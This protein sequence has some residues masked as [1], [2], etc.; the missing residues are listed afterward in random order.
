MSCAYNPEDALFPSSS[1][2]LSNLEL[3]DTHVYEPCIR[4]LLGTA[5]QVF[6]PKLITVPIGTALNLRFLLVIRRGAP[7][8][9][10]DAEYDN[11]MRVQPRGRALL[12]S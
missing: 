10:H 11:V 9:G 1:L 12:F 3:R 4:A 2:L 6:V 8:P 5:S 7:F